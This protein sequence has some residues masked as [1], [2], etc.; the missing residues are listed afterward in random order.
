MQICGQRK[1]P[2]LFLQNISGFVVGKDAE[3][4]GIAKDGAKL[5]TAVSCA[6]VPKITLIVGGSHGAGN[7]GMCGRAYNPRFLFSWPNSKISVMGPQQAASVLSQVK[8][9]Q[10]EKQTGVPMTKDEIDAFERPILDKF[11][12][13][14][15]PYYA[16]ARLWDDGVIQMED[17]RRVLG[18]ALRIVSKEFDESQ[19]HVYGVFRT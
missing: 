4:R 19:D 14:S 13:E 15:S 16:T 6:P 8:S 3:N 12:A 10:I 17:T 9:D 18:Q 1:I 11:E 7:Y 5:V 2:I